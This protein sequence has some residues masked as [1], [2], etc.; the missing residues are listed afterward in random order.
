MN[1]YKTI[2]NDWRTE[3]IVRV[4]ETVKSRKQ[5]FTYLDALNKS[6]LFRNDFDNCLIEYSRFINSNPL[7]NN[8]YFKYVNSYSKGK[9]L[10]LK[11]FKYDVNKLQDYYKKFDANK[12]KY[13]PFNLD[14]YNK[15]VLFMM[16]KLKGLYKSEYDTV[17]NVIVKDSRETNPLTNVPSVIRGELPFQVKEYDIKR[18]FSSFIDLELNINRE[19]DVYSL[20]DKR[21]FNTLLNLHSGCKNVTIESLRSQLVCVFGDRVNEVITEDRFN[22]LGQMYR[23]LTIYEKKAI[24]SFVTANN[25]EN[26]IRLHDGCFVLSDVKCDYLEIDKVTFAVKECIKPKIENHTFNFYTVD[27]NGENVI[28]SPKMYAEFF[29]QEN[30]IRITEQGNDTLT[31]FKDTNN[32]VIPFN[33]KTDVVPFLKE[34]INEFSTDAIEN[35]IANDNFSDIQKS[36]LL[37]DPIPLTYHR[38]SKETFGIAFKNGFAEYTKGKENIEVKRYK[39]IPNFF[40]PHQTQERNFEFNKE[41]EESVFQMFLTMASTG[42]NPLNEELTEADEEI[43]KKFCL[44]YGYL[45]HQYKD[46]SLNPAIVLSYA[47]ANNKTR[48]GRRGKSLFTKAIS[49]V[50]NV[51]LKAGNE[52]EPKYLFNFA[53]LTKAEDVFI[54]DDVFAGFNYNALYTNI[55]GGINC[56]R[57]GKAAQLIPFKDSPKFIITTNWCFRTEEDS[58]STE[59]RFYEFQFT[60]FFNIINTPKKVFNQTFFDDWDVKEWDLFYNFSFYCVALFIE[61]GLQRITYNKSEDNFKASFN[62][63]VIL[64]ELE[65]IINELLELNNEFSVSDF[66]N[67]YK[68][69]DN[70]L[71]FDNYF[72]HKNTKNLIDVY[73]KHNNLNLSYTNRRKWVKN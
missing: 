25:L 4:K 69:L 6:K 9:E 66:L 7:C 73:I 36:Y 53:D 62:N 48:N 32:V 58:N 55:S 67:H 45:I 27:E 43:F 5:D 15:Y 72:T 30:F 34:N 14:N 47:N 59:A 22:T 39:E 68:K 13:S 49:E 60:D 46:E 8:D 19:I 41:P 10:D 71:R 64:D 12:D 17:F 57:K 61:N 52:F 21:K 70:N 50:R 38:D 2:V 54:I 65:R 35:K 16:L 3:F 29:T 26:Y 20:I 56:Q 37:I 1:S 31:I 11:Y 24:E 23:D 40:A 44:M 18:A 42:K 28:T 63:D 51:M 33:H